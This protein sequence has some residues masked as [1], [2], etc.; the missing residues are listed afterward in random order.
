M[1]T[2]SLE[3]AY[4]RILDLAANGDFA[5][6]APGEWPVELVLAHLTV[7]DDLLTTVLRS[8]LANMP[9]PQYDNDQAV[10]DEHLE[11]QGSRA[12]LLDRLR[13]SSRQL[14]DL[15]AQLGPLDDTPVMVRIKD[16][17]TVVVDSQPMPVA[18][19]LDVHCTMHL[20]A[21]LSQLEEMRS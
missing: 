11:A 4:E 14:C 10:D 21:H 6:P 1:D 20:T 7:N 2:A 16:G 15:A 5:P 17:D 19:L 12:E 18:R 9:T 13:T 3:S 8:V